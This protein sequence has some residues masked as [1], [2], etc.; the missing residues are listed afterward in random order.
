VGEAAGNH[1][2][3]LYIYSQGLYKAKQEYFAAGKYRKA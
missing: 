1:G 2:E 3:W